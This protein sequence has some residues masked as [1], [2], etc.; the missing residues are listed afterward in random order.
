MRW[1]VL[2]TVAGAGIERQE[3]GWKTVVPMRICAGVR[4]DL[5]NEFNAGHLAVLLAH[6]LPNFASICTFFS[7]A[8]NAAPGEWCKSSKGLA[9]EWFQT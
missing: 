3:H 9:H 7:F 4:Q 1:T 8:R 2:R 5:V 6:V